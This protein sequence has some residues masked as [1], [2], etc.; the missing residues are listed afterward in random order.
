MVRTSIIA[1]AF[2][3]AAPSAA[4]VERPPEAYLTAPDAPVTILFADPT[5]V[6]EVCSAAAA[7]P[8]GFIAMAC[9]RDDLRIQLMP[10]PCLFPDEFYAS[11]QCHENA[12][13]TRTGLPG[14]RH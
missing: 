8:D 11:L 1:A 9:T 13:L 5:T 7:I 10:D 4:L 14:W 3:L 2:A 6:H 12:H